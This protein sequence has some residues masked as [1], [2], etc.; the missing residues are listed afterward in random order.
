MVTKKKVVFIYENKLKMKK[1]T[2][3]DIYIY[4]LK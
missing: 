2:I 3:C 4:Y 1:K